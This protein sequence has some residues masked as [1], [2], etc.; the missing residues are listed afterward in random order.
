MTVI[1]PSQRWKKGSFGGSAEP[2]DGV[3]EW[4]EMLFSRQKRLLL[5]RSFFFLPLH[6]VPSKIHKWGARSRDFYPLLSLLSF[7][8]CKE[9]DPHVHCK[10]GV[11][12]TWRWGIPNGMVSS[13]LLWWPVYNHIRPRTRKTSP[14]LCKCKYLVSRL[15]LGRGSTTL[16]AFV[17]YNGKRLNKHQQYL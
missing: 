14:M 10:K 8:T 16:Y 1:K 6:V 4:Y 9:I 17:A 13:L 15:E 12:I 3:N 11:R 7:S 2:E 5:L